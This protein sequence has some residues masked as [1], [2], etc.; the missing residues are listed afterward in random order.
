MKSHAPSVQTHRFSHKPQPPLRL[1][2]LVSLLRAMDPGDFEH[3]EGRII[4]YHRIHKSKLG[5]RFWRA[6]K[7]W[8]QHYQ[9]PQKCA[10]D[11]LASVS[12]MNLKKVRKPTGNPTVD[13][14][15]RYDAKIELT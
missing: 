14:N 13:F 3:I 9:D 8:S 10:E 15:N 11:F 12:F 4:E 5:Y 1:Q 7:T 6:D 2:D